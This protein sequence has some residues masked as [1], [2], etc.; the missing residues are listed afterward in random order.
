MSSKTSIKLSFFISSS[1]SCSSLKAS[2]PPRMLAFLTTLKVSSFL[3]AANESMQRPMRP[4]EKLEGSD[5]AKP[6]QASGEKP[7]CPWAKARIRLHT[8]TLHWSTTVSQGVSR[9]TWT[10]QGLISF[11]SW[12][13]RSAIIQHLP[14]NT[15]IIWNFSLGCPVEQTT[16]NVNNQTTS[17]GLLSKP[18]DITIQQYITSTLIYTLCI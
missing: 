7:G 17:V 15:G 10:L 13:A 11:I 3:L 16:D 5:W 12:S 9:P 6:S 4:Q 8:L 1:S 18:K 14:Q 2:R